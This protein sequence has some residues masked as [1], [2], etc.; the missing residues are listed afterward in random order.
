MKNAKR[1]FYY[2]MINVLVSACTV[3][4]VLYA[5]Q[6]LQPAGEEGGLAEENPLSLLLRRTSTAAPVEQ[7]YEAGITRTAV[8]ATPSI[9]TYRVQEGD[10]LSGIAEEFGT[11]LET[12]MALNQITDPDALT[13]G[14]ELLVPGPTP[15]VSVEESPTPGSATGTPAPSAHPAQVVIANLFGAGDLATERVRLLCQGE[16]EVLLAG[17]RLLDQDGYVFTFP[18]LTLYPGGAVDVYTGKGVN[19]VSALYWGLEKAVWE[20]GE[21]A[22][23]IDGEGNVV[24][25]MVVP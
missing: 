8:L 12:L 5:W 4:V 24:G 1:L 9:V 7:T 23:L 2:L 21:T 14:Q 25:K 3:L 17:W 13:L 10:T 19:D 18:Q 11:T 22:T 15:T 20:A 6:K 16:S